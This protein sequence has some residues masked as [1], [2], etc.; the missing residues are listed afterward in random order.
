[1]PKPREA[2]LIPTPFLLSCRRVF[3][4][5]LHSIWPIVLLFLLPF[6]CPWVG[7]GY[8]W[9]LMGP[10][11]ARAHGG[12]VPGP[13]KLRDFLSLSR[14]LS[15]FLSF[16]ISIHITLCICIYVLALHAT[17]Q[18]KIASYSMTSC[19]IMLCHIIF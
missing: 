1:M 5:N 16:T 4:Y 19:H 6:D 15:L 14:S 12:I 9:V 13:Q 3:L 11:R 7:C 17:L 8:S 2:A 18:Y 10:A